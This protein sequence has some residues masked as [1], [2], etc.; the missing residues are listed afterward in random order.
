VWGL[1]AWC[2]AY[3]LNFKFVHDKPHYVEISTPRAR[4]IHIVG[5]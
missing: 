2:L 5:F 3:V 4:A 1:V